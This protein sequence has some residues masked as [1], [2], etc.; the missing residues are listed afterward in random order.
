MAWNEQTEA[1][2]IAAG[3]IGVSW[4]PDDL[5]SRGKCG[6]KILQYQA[7]G[8]P[9]VANPVGAHCEMIR[10]G[11]TGFLATTPDEWAGRRL[12]AGRRR[13][14]AAADG[15]RWPAAGRGGLLGLGLGRDLRDLDDRDLAGR[16]PVLP[17][18]SIGLR[19]P[20][21]A[22]GFR[23]ARRPGQINL[24]LSTRLAIDEPLHPARTSR[25]SRRGPDGAGCGKHR[26]RR[27]AS[28]DVQAARL[29]VV[30]V[31]QTSAGGRGTAG[32][33]C[34]WERTACG[35]TSGARQGSLT[36]IKSGP[37]RIV[38]RVELPQGT[39]YIKHFLVPDWRAIAPPVGSP[40]QGTERGEA[41][42]APGLDRSADDHAGRAGRTAEA[43]VPVRELPGHARDLRRDP[44][45]R[46]RRAPA[47]GAGP[48]RCGRSIRQKLAE[49]LAV[50]TA[51]LHDAGLLHQDFHP[52]NIMVRL[53]RRQTPELFMIDLDA[54]RKS[55]RVT[56][57]LARQNLALLDHF[58]WLRS[59]R[60]DRYRFLKTYLRNRSEPPP[61]VAPR[62]PARSRTR[63]ASGPSGSGGAG[64]GVAGR[65]TSISK[66]IAGTQPGAWRRA[67]ST[68]RKS[69]LC[70]TIPTC[71]SGDPRPPS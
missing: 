63:P 46:V 2:E 37:H 69:A 14:A 56:W 4:I 1:R 23:A 10:D 5:W 7:A 38:Y 31:R 62:S 67:T 32:A 19:R 43:E 33:T 47:P 50:M 45:R 16:R 21:S 58:F 28:A 22:P 53:G 3:H 20:R 18:R 25:T 57:K 65:R 60:T 9:V 11:E 35:W 41:L 12:A 68:R 26:K 54:L 40:R 64:A 51:R 52:G 36:T 61:Q 8:L 44:A 49:A 42:P 48:S 6:L 59:S 13:A 17:G 34:C 27:R 39:I 15:T 70:W 30:A 71:R 29:G 55:R 24:E 66:S